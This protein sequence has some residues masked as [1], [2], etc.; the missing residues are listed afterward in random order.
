MRRRCGRRRCSFAVSRPAA[1]R[2]QVLRHR[3]G[4]L[5]LLRGCRPASTHVG[6]FRPR[7]RCSA[8]TC[9]VKGLG[10][11][12]CQCGPVSPAWHVAE[13]GGGGMAQASGVFHTGNGGSRPC[14][15]WA[16]LPTSDDVPAHRTQRWSVRVWQSR[17]RCP[18]LSH[19]HSTVSSCRPLWPPPGLTFGNDCEDGIGFHGSCSLA[20]PDACD[21]FAY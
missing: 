18:P 12:A 16:C 17:Q 2:S 7:K 9:S 4:M 19:L 11:V 13:G 14:I 20:S 15:A 21:R 8:H 3:H 5:S 6:P 10:C 1:V